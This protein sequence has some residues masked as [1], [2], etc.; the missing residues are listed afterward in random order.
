MSSHITVLPTAREPVTC[1]HCEDTQIF[2][3]LTGEQYKGFPERSQMYTEKLN[4]I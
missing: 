3:E 4:T 1:Q 2:R